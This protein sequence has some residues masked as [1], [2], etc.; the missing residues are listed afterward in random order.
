MKRLFLAAFS[1]ALL[2]VP[3]VSRAQ[4]AEVDEEEG[5]HMTVTIAPRLEGNY[6][7]WEADNQPG[8]NLSLGSSMLYMIMDGNITDNLSL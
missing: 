7:K 6:G 4:A 8:T 3:F 1:A 5:N 2:L